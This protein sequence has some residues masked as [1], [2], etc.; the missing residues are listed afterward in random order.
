MY[1]AGTLDRC[2]TDGLEA[3]VPIFAEYS[4]QAITPVNESRTTYFFALGPWSQH[5]H[6][7]QMYL[8]LGQL[9][10]SEDRV[11][12]ESQQKVIDRNPGRRMMNLAADQAI[13][14]FRARIHA[15]MQAETV[16]S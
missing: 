5:A 13:T 3:Q 11:M 12:L 7:K 1:E 9:A 10:F 6:L 4:C 2:S 14:S 15:L 16:K 8:D